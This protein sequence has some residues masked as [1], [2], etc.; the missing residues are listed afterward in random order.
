V[1]AARGQ[2]GSFLYGYQACDPSFDH[3]NGPKKG[4]KKPVSMSFPFHGNRLL[5]VANKY[6]GASV[7]K[8]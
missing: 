4:H 5:S 1:K 7:K 8:Y 6:I 3:R 2:P